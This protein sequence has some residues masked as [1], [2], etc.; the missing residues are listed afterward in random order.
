M[1][2]IEAWWDRSHDWNVVM[3]GYVLLRK[4]RPATR[5]GGVARYVRE[6]LDCTEY[7]PGVDEEG[8]ERL[9]VGIKGQAGMGDTVVVPSIADHWIRTKK[10]TRPFTGS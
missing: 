2:I 10:P 1:A 8:V 7:C 5:G 6:Q 4:D 9:W 3:D